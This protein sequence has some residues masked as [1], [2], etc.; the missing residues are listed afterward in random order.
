[1][2][3]MHVG[4]E[5]EGLDQEATAGK[6]LPNTLSC[7]L[8]GPLHPLPAGNTGWYFHFPA[9]APKYQEV[10]LSQLPVGAH[11]VYAT[12]FPAGTKVVGVGA[13]LPLCRCCRC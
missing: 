6:G 8:P 12:R 9:G 13:L 3:Y 10:W 1:M 4:S 5:R 2:V 7:P 11:I